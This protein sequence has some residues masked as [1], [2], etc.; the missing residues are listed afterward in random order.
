M[1]TVI[2]RNAFG[3]AFVDLPNYEYERLKSCVWHGPKGFSSKKAL[4]PVYGHELG[5]LFQEI[6]K[7]PT[8]TG[9]EAREYLEHLRDD[10][11][12]TMADVT[13]VYVFIQ[14]YRAMT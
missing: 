11:L 5:P 7:V 9:A 2:N 13:E 10:K 8:V 14:K 1:L 4:Q 3:N 12:T 6:L